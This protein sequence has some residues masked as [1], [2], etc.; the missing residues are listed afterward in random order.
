MLHC[1]Q[2]VAFIQGIHLLLN[3]IFGIPHWGIQTLL[4]WLYCLVYHNK[5]KWGEII[6]EFVHSGICLLNDKWILF[7]LLMGFHV[8][9]THF[10]A[11]AVC[12]SL[13][14]MLLW[15]T[16]KGYRGANYSSMLSDIKKYQVRPAP[17]CLPVHFLPQFIGDYLL[18]SVCFHVLGAAP[19]SFG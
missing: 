4:F 19:T 18:D 7:I 5:E 8:G 9:V 1:R 17:V 15:E 3:W 12:T 2:M 6:I 10:P 16:D 14:T 11:L 13:H